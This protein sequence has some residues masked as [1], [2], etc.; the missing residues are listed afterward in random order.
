MQRIL[1]YDPQGKL[2]DSFKSDGQI[3]IKNRVEDALVFL[4]TCAPSAVAVLTE[5][6]REKVERVIRS[7]KMSADVPVISICSEEDALSF[8]NMGADA[9]FLGKGKELFLYETERLLKHREL[10]NERME[11]RQK[12]LFVSL[13]AYKCMVGEKEIKMPRKELEILFLLASSPDKVFSRD[14][15]LDEVW[16]TYYIGDPRTVDVHILRI[17]NKI[18]DSICNINTVNRAGYKFT[19]I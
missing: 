12:D 6:E 2:K 18:K 10:L 5:T 9:V 13:S 8:Y 16:G 19:S 11:I 7:I 15:I 4:K 14:E 3:F 17:R 1:I